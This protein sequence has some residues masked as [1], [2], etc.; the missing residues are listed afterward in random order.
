M[1]KLGA[2]TLPPSRVHK[3]RFEPPACQFEKSD[4]FG[5]DSGPSRGDRCRRTPAHPRHSWYPPHMIDRACHGNFALKGVRTRRL[6]PELRRQ[7]LPA[8]F[9]TLRL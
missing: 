6:E 8:K 3:V 2:E 9:G 7:S 1:S 4:G 5:P